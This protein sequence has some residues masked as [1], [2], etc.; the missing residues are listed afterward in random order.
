MGRLSGIS[1]KQAAK[2]FQAF[3]YSVDHQTESHMILYCSSRVPLSI[4]NHRELAPGLVQG[5]LRKSGI[6]VDEFLKQVK[7]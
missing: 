2:A 6:S 5:L 7:K 3:G 4:P 1:G